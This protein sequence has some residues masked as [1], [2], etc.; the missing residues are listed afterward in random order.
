MTREAA[1]PQARKE[2]GNLTAT[3][4]SAR[5]ERHMTWIDATSQ[6]VRYAIRL[7]RQSP[8]FAL[9]AVLSLGVG[10][11]AATAVL[12]VVDAF[13]FRPLPFAH[14][15]RLVWPAEV[16]PRDFLTCSRCAWSTAA[17]MVQ[18]WATR[19]H[20]FDAI[21][22]FAPGN[23]V[24]QHNDETESLG[25]NAITPGFLDLLGARPRVGREFASE[26]TIAAATP[27]VMVSHEF[28]QARLGGTTDVIGS[29]LLVQDDA[30]A[31]LSHRAT[32]VGVLPEQFRFRAKAPIWTPMRLSGTGSRTARNLTAIG[33][34]HPNI[35]IAAANSE[36]ATLSARLALT[37][38]QAYGGWGAQVQPLRE[39]LTIGVAKGRSL[40][41]ALAM[42]VLLIATLNV[43]GLLVARAVARQR[44][45][46]MRA[47][48][49][50]G[51]GRL[52]GQTLVEGTCIALA[53]GVLGALIAAWITRF[54]PRWFS[55]DTAGL[56]V[57]IDH[58]M[59]VMAALLSALV[60]VAAALL[61]A[62]R[63]GRVD[64]VQCLRAG[65]A[66][67]G[68]RASRTSNALV[69]AQ[70][71]LALVM[72][73]T[74]MLLG[75]DFLEVRYLDLG[76]DPTGLYHTSMRG[77]RE[78]RANPAAWRVVPEAAR[79]R[80]ARLPGVAAVALEHRSG[81]HPTLV[82][83]VGGEAPRSGLTPVLSAV[84][85]SYFA[86]LG[87]RLMMG[88][89][90]VQTD[91]RGAPP[92][93]IINK[94]AADVLWPGTSPIGRLLFIGDS[95]SAG[96]ELTVVGVVANI[97]RGEMIERHWPMVFRPFDQAPLYHAALTL[98]LRVS[99]GT[100][101]ESVLASAGAVIR[102]VTGH[103]T[104]AFD[105]AEERLGLRMHDRASNAAMLTLLAAF[106][107]LLA[108]MGTY[109]TV[110]Y[111]V[112]QRTRE[113]GIR[114][115]L[116]ARRSNVATVVARGAM[117]SV[118][119]GVL[120]GAGGTLVAARLL[121]RF[122]VATS[123]TSPR[124]FIVSTALMIVVALLAAL[125]PARR[126]TRVDALVALRAE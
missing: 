80:I 111:S 103:A 107:L 7:L 106:G 84:D 102:Q 86:A 63:A 33:R 49:G 60:G 17:P 76:Y 67:S 57:Q 81:V 3:K 93:A 112:A 120:L 119:L 87:A 58:R 125:V 113:I 110:A 97:E 18:E 53:G 24:W 92:V 115:A 13:D 71:A 45:F 29:T 66:S 73:A 116:G 62:L 11:G 121:E 59:L 39:L 48:L 35:D 126:A 51:R 50:A 4:E 88:R 37:D 32:I 70:I 9:I 74:A 117:R 82:R 19:A 124:V 47:A 79:S 27:V 28:W 100:S 69:A 78:E 1:V 56:A 6:D 72:L 31:A 118:A 68:P 89:L 99:P 109:G 98:H 23:V 105:S 54:I 85:P 34:L 25:A 123:A 114:I 26:D 30:D 38:S 96:E 15:D 101:S 16:T 55:I 12:S 94:A 90:F 104:S 44:E 20:S 2:F 122:L 22:G 65:M 83:P 21:G 42:V 77:S 14:S 40:L 95:A 5:A 75:R 61:P 64:A 41:L 8:A 52:I 43:A 91:A 10:I 36:L 108:T 46:A